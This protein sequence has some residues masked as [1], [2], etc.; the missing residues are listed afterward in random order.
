MFS[1]LIIYL[2]S[3]SLIPA[4]FLGQAAK[5]TGNEVPT[6]KDFTPFYLYYAYQYK[7]K[8]LLYG[9]DNLDVKNPSKLIVKEGD[10]YKVL[11]DNF[12]YPY[13]YVRTNKG[14]VIYTDRGLKLYDYESDTL[15]AMDDSAII[16]DTI[17]PA[18]KN[19]FAKDY[20]DYSLLDLNENF[21]QRYIKADGNIIYTFLI[22]GIKNDTEYKAFRY[23]VDSNGK[24]C[25]SAPSDKDIDIVDSMGDKLLISETSHTGKSLI[26]YDGK[27]AKKYEAPS[28]PS[29]PKGYS[30]LLGFDSNSNLVYRYSDYKNTY[31]DVAK[32]DESAGKIV[33]TATLNLNDYDYL[34][35]DFNH[36]FWATF[37]NDDSQNSSICKLENNSLTPKYEISDFAFRFSVYDDKHITSWFSPNQHENYEKGAYLVINSEEKQPS[38]LDLKYKAAYDATIK[39]I[40]KASKHSVKAYF[41]TNNGGATDTE[42]VVAAVKNGLQKDIQKA[43]EAINALPDEL[44]TFKQTFS[45]MLDNYQHPI[46]ERIVTI[47]NE[48]KLDPNQKDLNLG[49][50]LIA[51]MDAGYK[52]SY[53]EALDKIQ[54]ALFDKAVDLVDKAVKTKNPADLKAAKDCIT[55]LKTNEFLTDDINGFISKLETKLNQ[56]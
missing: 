5:A 36:N 48:T 11:A 34:T 26:V 29:Y 47:I 38:E 40:E 10:N 42:K 45:S 7:N 21:F 44:L 52:A 22:D 9:D 39:A 54:M 15:K 4:S 46:Y 50:Y 55:E 24:I 28:Y 18:L 12:S 20:S 37:L 25:Y 30:R 49:R 31:L 51:D 16:K 35:R 2:F 23:F 6:Y 56:N 19:A 33:T 41:D 53:S 13:H 14:V 27:E 1:M 3:L 43:R 17:L 32:I 8:T